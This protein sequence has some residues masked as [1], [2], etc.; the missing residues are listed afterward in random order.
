[1]RKLVL[2]C[3]SLA[4]S[5]CVGSIAKTVVTAPVKVVSKT[6]DLATTSQK[7]ADE[8]RGR[9]MRKEEKKARKR[10]KREGY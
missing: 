2:L 3:L 4:V 1:M 10:A 6:V 8:K 5:G 7:E 9:Q